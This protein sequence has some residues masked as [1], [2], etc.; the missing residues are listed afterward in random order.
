MFLSFRAPPPPLFS[1]LAPPVGTHLSG[2]TLQL[3][4]VGGDLASAAK[5]LEGVKAVTGTPA[6]ASALA[7]LYA[8][9]GDAEKGAAVVV[10]A[11]ESAHRGEHVSG[12]GAFTVAVMTG[13]RRIRNDDKPRA[14][15]R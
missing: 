4:T 3:Y 14:V 7:G 9:M 11:A 5:T 2:D 6:A 12:G 13:K 15:L 8:G 10:A 1:F